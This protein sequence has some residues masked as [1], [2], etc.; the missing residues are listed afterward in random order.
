MIT[1]A[2]LRHSKMI[3]QLIVVENL[4]YF[5]LRHISTRKSER[6][7]DV[8]WNFVVKIVADIGVQL[9]LMTMNFI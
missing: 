4:A 5:L 8:L 9:K 2:K 6:F 3:H 7:M 1:I